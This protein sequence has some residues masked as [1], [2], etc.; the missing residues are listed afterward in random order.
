MDH[1]AGAIGQTGGVKGCNVMRIKPAHTLVQQRLRAT[2]NLR[3]NLAGRS[4]YVRMMC[5]TWPATMRGLSNRLARS[6]NSM[7]SQLVPARV[8]LT[9]HMSPKAFL[10][11]VAPHRAS[12]GRRNEAAGG[13]CGT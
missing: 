1:I 13:E 7:G 6:W 10:V 9:G 3:A 12:L 8:Q 4:T 11:S 5:A 2:A